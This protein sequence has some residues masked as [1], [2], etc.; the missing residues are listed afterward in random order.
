MELNFYVQFVV[1]ALLLKEV[2]KT[3]AKIVILVMQNQKY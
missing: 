2:K 1:H 3:P